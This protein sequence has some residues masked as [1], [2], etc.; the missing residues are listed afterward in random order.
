MKLYQLRSEP[1]RN[2][3]NQWSDLEVSKVS[4]LINSRKY[5]MSIF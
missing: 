2:K 4:N 1:I 3:E 5:K